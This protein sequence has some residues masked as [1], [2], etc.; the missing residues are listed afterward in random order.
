M[1]SISSELL[2]GSLSKPFQHELDNETKTVG[3]T[4]KLQDKKIF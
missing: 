4:N 1:F 3:I 2:F